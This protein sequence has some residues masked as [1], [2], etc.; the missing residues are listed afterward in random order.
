MSPAQPRPTQL[1]SSA[2]P[3]AQP[4]YLR[5]SSSQTLHGTASY[6]GLSVT[7]ALSFPL[8]HS[9]LLLN[10][11]R[12]ETLATWTIADRANDHQ[13]FRRGNR[14]GLCEQIPRLFEDLYLIQPTQLSATPV[15]WN[16]LYSEHRALVAT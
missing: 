1:P 8:L 6:F 16:K 7:Y 11:Q 14:I 9:P 12:R 5:A 15:F 3:A 13:G 10:P 2:T 4:E